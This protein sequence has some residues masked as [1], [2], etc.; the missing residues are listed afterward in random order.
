MSVRNHS[1]LSIPVLG[2]LRHW[3][4]RIDPDWLTRHQK[5]LVLAAS[6]AVLIAVSF[7]A[8]AMMTGHDKSH[9]ADPKTW[10]AVAA[11]A[12]AAIV[13]FERFGLYRAI[14]RF[15]TGKSMPSIMA[16]ATIG[17]AALVLTGLALQAEISLGTAFTHG[18]LV[19]MLVPGLR[20]GIRTIIRRPIKLASAPVIIYGAGNAG[21]QLVAALHLGTEYRPVA[22]VDDETSL[23]GATINGVRVYAS[24]ELKALT[25]RWHIREVLLAMPSISRTKLRRIVLRLETL[26]VAVNTIPGMSDLVAGRAKYTDL[27]PVTPEDML[28][29]DPVPPD[30]Q[31]MKRN[32]AG[33]IVMV[34]GAGGSIGSEL[35]RQIMAQK[36]AL[37]VMVD[38][39]EYALYAITTSLRDDPENDHDL[40]VPLLGS[41]QDAA[42]MQSILKR[43]K[44]QTVYHAAAYKHVVMVEEN[45]VEGIYNNVFGTKTLADAACAAGVESFILISSD[46]TVRPA[47][48]MGASKRL[49][50]LICQG[51]AKSACKT[52]FSMVRFGN[53]LG[54]SGSVIPRFREQI[55]RGGPVTVTHPDI[56]RYFMTITEA[57]QLVIQAGAMARGGDVFVLDMGQ[58]V[59]ILELA[60]SMIRQYGLT[61]YMLG[62]EDKAA[63]EAG[64]IGIQITGLQKGEKLYEELLI[65]G[66]PSGTAHKRIMTA[67]EQFLAPAELNSLLEALRAACRNG[68]LTWIQSLLLSA[69]LDYRPT[70]VDIH[71]LTW[72]VAIPE[73][74]APLRIAV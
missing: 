7:A 18:I 66:T 30:P 40:M 32:I 43:F 20:F 14:T 36:P 22:F 2:A 49:A 54:S 50:E 13:G 27:R 39:S 52:V 31:L 72:P 45:L 65:A 70:D 34:T 51:Y 3:T 23:H 38:I 37:L 48:V 62:D 11:F 71:D 26:G 68:D 29:R 64:D 63:V 35:C 15:V 47:N 69:P 33:K 73:E 61:P 44:V 46:K 17:T 21:Q 28:G 8:A 60:K 25:E 19:L 24:S 4:R 5:R 41:V 58:P 9:L 57:A 6:D 59:R 12:L 1:I 67:S 42:R 55:E 10:L 74:K 56:T 16:G 53:V